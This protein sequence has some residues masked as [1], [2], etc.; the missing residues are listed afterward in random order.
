MN[1]A[2]Y[3]ASDYD[4]LAD[5]PLV[6]AAPNAIKTAEFA[7]SGKPH[8]VIFFDHTER[9][10]NPDAYVAVLR[11]RRRAETRIMGV[12]P[13]DRYEFCFD[14]DGMGGGLEHL[15][16][17]RIALPSDAPPEALAGFFAHEFFHLWNVKRIRPRV[18]G[19][20]DYVNPPKTRNLWFAEGVT[21]YYAAITLR[22]A[23][24][25]LP[26]QFM[27]SWGRKNR[28]L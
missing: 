11:A 19:P 7:V 18:L 24:F 9:I 3:A 2:S 14:V 8:R 13:Y 17:C 4:T 1:D 25:E 28:R 22:R 21:E 20:F 12:T 10:K 6:M 5:T 26:D 15:N 23:G 16:A 27:K